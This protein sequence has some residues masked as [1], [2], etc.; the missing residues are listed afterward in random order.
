MPFDCRSAGRQIKENFTTEYMEIA[1]K[2]LVGFP[3]AKYLVTLSTCT[4]HRQDWRAS[5]T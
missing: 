5:M 1:M 4:Q 3:Q 2:E